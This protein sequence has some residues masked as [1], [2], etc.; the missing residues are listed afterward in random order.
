MYLKN[1]CCGV[2]PCKFGAGSVGAVGEFHVVVE[3]G[4]V[5]DEEVPV[6]LAVVPDE[7][8]LELPEVCVDCVSDV[9]K[10]SCDGGG[11]SGA[12]GGFG[13]GSVGGTAP[14]G[15]AASAI[16]GEGG[17]PGC[18][19]AAEQK[20]IAA[21]ATICNALKRFMQILHERILPFNTS[22]SSIPPEIRHCLFFP[23]Q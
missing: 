10:V 6:E 19:R 11:I 4:E 21:R 18:A 9:L 13:P 16:G 2:S 23:I 5:T 15:G 3:D 22:S 14:A 8:V 12:P 20:E 17:I 7:R 1:T